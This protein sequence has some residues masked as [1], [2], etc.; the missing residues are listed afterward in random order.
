MKK[1]KKSSKKKAV[2]DMEAFEKELN[3]SKKDPAESAKS[4]KGADEE[5]EEEE[6]DTS[7]L[8]NVDEA[9]LG[10]NP[11][12]RPDVPIG[13]DAGTEAWLSSDR[14]YTYAEVCIFL[15]STISIFKHALC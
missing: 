12:L 14:D 13:V 9:E 6:V 10:D 2:L 15:Q 1:K 3:E 5:E 4:K 11:F 8:D 7:H